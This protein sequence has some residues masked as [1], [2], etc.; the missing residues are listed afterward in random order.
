MVAQSSMQ[1]GFVSAIVP[2]LSLA[3]VLAFAKAQQFSCVE[4]MCWPRGKAER[5]YAGITHVEV[6]R[7][8]ATKA[9]EVHALCAEH[10]VSLSALGY[11]PN[12]LDP[13]R[14]AAQVAVA[15]LKKVIKAASLLGLNTVNTFVGRD[16][17]Q[18]VDANWVRFL[19]TW[20]PL[21]A[22]PR[23]MAC[24]LA[25]KIARCILRAMNGPVVKTCLPP[26]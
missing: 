17:T 11:Y 19:K 18:S 7:F 10:G 16:W 21:V 1:L 9:D 8:T 23:I 22:L 13:D 6:E 26:R 5:K 2:E 14:K 12:P 24:V 15:H 3:E 25:L 4:A 20:R